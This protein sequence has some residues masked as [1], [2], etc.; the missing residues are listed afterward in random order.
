MIHGPYNIFDLTE[1]ILFNGDPAIGHD[2]FH[3]LLAIV[4]I[5]VQLI[6]NLLD[7]HDEL[8]HW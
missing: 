8:S 5:L 7:Q 3:F 6:D 2:L 1:D 4:K